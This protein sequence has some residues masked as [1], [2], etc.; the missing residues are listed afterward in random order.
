M[1]DFHDV[2][3]SYEK[4]LERIAE[5]DGQLSDSERIRIRFEAENASLKQRIAELDVEYIFTR[6][7]ADEIAMESYKA[8]RALGKNEGMERAAYILDN[9]TFMVGTQE[10][11]MP[12]LHGVALAIRKEIDK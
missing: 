11:L 6:K 9:H 12:Q 4:A 10:Q 3:D 8:G 2:L 7:E 1:T 5:L